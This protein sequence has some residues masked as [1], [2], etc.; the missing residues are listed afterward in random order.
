MSRR[1]IIVAN[2]LIDAFTEA[3]LLPDDC[4]RFDIRAEIGEPVLLSYEVL[5][6]ER[7]LGLAA[8]VKYPGPDENP[9]VAH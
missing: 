9:G 4:I 6:D 5:G 8:S 1:K 7:L 2:K 3:G